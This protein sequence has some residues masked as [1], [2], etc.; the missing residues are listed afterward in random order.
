MTHKLVLIQKKIHAILWEYAGSM[1][2]AM[3]DANF[4]SLPCMAR[5]LQLT[6]S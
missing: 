3:K 6:V 2:K 1:E 5:T 4:P